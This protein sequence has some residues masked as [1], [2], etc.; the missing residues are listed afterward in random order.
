VRSQLRMAVAGIVIIV[1]ALALIIETPGSAEDI[2]F[3]VIIISMLLV[4]LRGRRN[5][6]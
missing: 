4:I 2:G 3:A 5:L 1:I 6:R